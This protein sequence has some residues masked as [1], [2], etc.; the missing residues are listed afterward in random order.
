MSIHHPI[1]L[2]ARIERELH[3]AEL[4]IMRAKAARAALATLLKGL[5]TIDGTQVR[6]E[7]TTKGPARE[8]WEEHG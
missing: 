7:F 4:A 2:L 3:E 1:A 5:V 8:A 6:S